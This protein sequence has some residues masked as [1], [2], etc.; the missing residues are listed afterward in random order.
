MRFPVVEKGSRLVVHIVILF[1]TWMILSSPVSARDSET[2]FGD[3]ERISAALLGQVY[4][5]P[6]QTRGLPD[7]QTMEPVGTIYTRTINVPERDWSEGFPGVENSFEWFAIEYAGMFKVREAGNYSL[8]LVSDDGSKL[9]I[10]DQLIIDNDGVHATRSRSA[11]IYLDKSA[12][13]IILQYFQGPRYHI[14]LQLLYTPEG[15]G[16]Q[17][18][19]G[20]DFLLTTPSPYRVSLLT[21]AVQGMAVHFGTTFWW[22]G[23]WRHKYNRAAA[24]LR[25]PGGKTVRDA[26]KAATRK[27]MTPL[28]LAFSKSA[29][30]SRAGQLMAKTARQLEG[31][32]RRTSP[33]WNK[34][35]VAGKWAG[36]GFVVVGVGISVYNI[37][38]APEG[39]VGE[40]VAEE[41]GAWTGALAGGALCAKIGFVLGSIV[42]GPGNAIGAVVGGVVGSI[43]GA[44]V[45]SETGKRLY[46]WIFGD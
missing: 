45:G 12:H 7:F 5:L 9:F 14:A 41:A 2:I 40:V 1:T 8:R 13:T 20:S 31:S 42:P 6:P 22:D 27:K 11:S 35:G 33:F 16:E 10:D 26:L 17:V 23:Y 44:I 3:T 19:P 21:R 18:F 28:G 4:L 38:T 29:D 25:G 36:R 15:G 30:R 37:A 43:G 32:A 34:V 39:Q 24:N 46:N